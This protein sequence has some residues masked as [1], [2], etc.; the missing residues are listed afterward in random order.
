MRNTARPGFTSWWFS[1]AQASRQVQQPEQF[2][3][4]ALN[5]IV[6]SLAS[7]MIL[8]GT[9]PNRRVIFID[10]IPGIEV[11]RNLKFQAPRQKNG[12]QAKSNEIP[13]VN[14]Q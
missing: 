10:T 3:C 4:I 7:H 6:F 14:I 12:G 9:M 13:N 2:S 8:N 11:F 1:K 5:S